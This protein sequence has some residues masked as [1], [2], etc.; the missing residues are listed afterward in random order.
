MYGYSKTGTKARG[1]NAF[2]HKGNCPRVWWSRCS[3]A[4]LPFPASCHSCCPFAALTG[5]LFSALGIFTADDAFL[6]IDVVRGGY[7]RARFL[8]AVKKKL[9]RCVSLA[10][11]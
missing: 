5:Q 9:V 1:D 7:N 4:R 2:F 11:R 6:D 10:L 8:R 3:C